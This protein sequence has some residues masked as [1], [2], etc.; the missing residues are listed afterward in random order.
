MLTHRSLLRARAAA[1]EF[2]VSRSRVLRAAW[3]Q[4]FRRLPPHVKSVLGPQRNLLLL[5]ELLCAAGSPGSS[6]P[7]DLALGFPP[8]GEVRRSGA[9][10]PPD[11]ADGRRP[12]PPQPHGF[13]NQTTFK[14]VQ[15]EYLRCPEICDEILQMFEPEAQSGRAEWLPVKAAM[16]RALCVP[17]FAVEQYSFPPGEPPKRKVRLIDDFTAPGANDK[18]IV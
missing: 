17:R 2:W 11:P 4:E 13:A 1:V 3:A 5:G 18:A 15:D 12:V 8:V 6:L 10:P 9:L 7:A 14:R 16:R